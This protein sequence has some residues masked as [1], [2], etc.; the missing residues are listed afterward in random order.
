[1][2]A[3]CHPDEQDF[4]RLVETYQTSLRRMCYAILRDEDVA[5]DAVQEAFLKAYMTKKAFR[6]GMQREDLAHAH[7]HQHLPR[8]PAQ[9]MVPPS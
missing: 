6:G 1:M 8:L 4:I 5:R 9:R 7:C 3:A 2:E